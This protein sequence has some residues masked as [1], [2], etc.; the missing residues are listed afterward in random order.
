M[1][2]LRLPLHLYLLLAVACGTQALAAPAQEDFSAVAQDVAPFVSAN[3]FNAADRSF[4]QPLSV[5][6]GELS[7]RVELAERQ[8]CPS[9]GLLEGEQQATL[10]RSGGLCKVAT[11][12]ASAPGHPD[13]RQVIA[14]LGGGGKGTLSDL[15]LSFYYL[16]QG[17]VLPQVILS[18]FTGGTRC[19][20]VSAIVGAGDAGQWYAVQLPEQNGFGPPSVVDVAH[21]GGR[22]FIFPDKRFD[23]VFAAYDFSVGPD[24]IY[25]YA[26]GKLNVI[27]RQP[28]FRPYMAL[29][30]RA[31]PGEE[32]VPAPRSR[33]V[34]GYLAGYVATSANAGQ[35][36]AGWRSMLARYNPQSPY[37]PKW[38]TL[39]KSAWGK[40]RM[41]CP[42]PYVRTVPYPQQLALFL[43]QTGYITHAQCVALG[44]DPE[45]IQHEQ[46]AIRTAATAHWHAT[47]N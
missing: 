25:E 12:V 15:N 6:V 33:E 40:G 43:L 21:D 39:D 42:A 44:Y 28:R 2:Y 41:A 30:V 8:P 19:C 45:K 35:L 23:A 38:C 26:Q 7:V 24:V 22:Q 5:T 32:D 46:D 34:N 27:T 11:L 29:S 10:L 31:M 37:L 20:L 36:Q 16:E 3:V 1:R 4:S 13:F 47:H 14:A 17:E 18:G 9:H